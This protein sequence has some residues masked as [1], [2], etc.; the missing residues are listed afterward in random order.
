MPNTGSPRSTSIADLAKRLRL[1]GEAETSTL[2]KT[3]QVREAFRV[4]RNRCL[5][6][7][8]SMA[9]LLPDWKDVDAYTYE[10]RLSSEFRRYVRERR[11]DA[12]GSAAKKTKAAETGAEPLDEYLA[13]ICCAKP[14]VLMPHVAMFMLRVDTFLQSPRGRKFDVPRRSVQGGKVS[15]GG[16]GGRESQFDRYARIMKILEF[17][18]ARDV[19]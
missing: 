1:P 2:L 9:A 4:Y 13:K 12:G 15:S 14:F 3:D 8:R 17:L 16:L 11:R 6:S 7:H 5:V 18:V 10:L 19:G